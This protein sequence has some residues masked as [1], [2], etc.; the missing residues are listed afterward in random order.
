[1][2]KI[3]IVKQVKSG[4][5]GAF[6]QLLLM[7]AFLL[8][9]VPFNSKA[10][11]KTSKETAIKSAEAALSKAQVNLDKIER[12]LVISDSLIVAGQSMV[13][14]ATMELKNIEL[15][16]KKLEKEDNVSRKP[17]EKQMKSKD[18]DERKGA[19]VE[20]KK[21]DA[22]VKT[23]FKESANKLKIANKQRTVG[24]GNLNKGKSMKSIAQSGLKTA[25]SNVKL[26]QQKLDKANK[27]K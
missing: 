3:T 14:E 19:M 8:A 17:L 23:N 27:I 10:Q 5:C 11:V 4:L 2:K 26:A 16:S 24:E 1:M 21:L 20:I 7:I 22:M 25:K 15:E 18:I 9:V 6:V 12:Q 13:K